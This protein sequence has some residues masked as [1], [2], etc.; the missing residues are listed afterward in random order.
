M[1]ITLT[2]FPAIEYIY[3]V[4]AITTNEV[5]TINNMVLNILSKGFYSAQI[6]KVLQ[7]EPIIISNFGGS[8]GRSIKHYLDKAKIKSDIVWSDSETPHQIK[9]TANNTNEYISITNKEIDIAESS[10]TRIGYKLIDNL[11]K[12][13]TLVLSGD[14]PEDSIDIYKDW[15]EKVK[16]N[17]IKLVVSSGQKSVWELLMKEKPY[18]IFLTEAQIKRLELYNEDR[19]ELIKTFSKFLGYGLH[20]ICILLDNNEAITIS[21]HKVCQVVYTHT[22]LPLEQHHSAKAGAFLGALAISVNRQY[23]QEKMS[24]LCLASALSA[25]GDLSKKICTK[26]DIDSRYKRTK[27]IQLVTESE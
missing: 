20:Y 26:K 23:E 10:L 2:P 24:K 21:K 4:D 5:H 17:N 27:V 8:T 19:G 7:E 11:S 1:I 18:S 12:V 25:H 6:M 14:I 16:Q 3:S 9:I 15:L 22:N 13:T